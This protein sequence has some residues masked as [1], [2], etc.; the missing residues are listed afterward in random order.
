MRFAGKPVFEISRLGFKDKKLWF[1]QMLLRI[2]PPRGGA[3]EIHLRRSELTH[4]SWNSVSA[5]TV[6][7]MRSDWTFQFAGETTTGDDA[8]GITRE[9]FEIMTKEVF[10]EGIGLFKFTEAHNLAYQLSLIHI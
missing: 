5:L 2:R 6:E 1:N 10:N 8:G 4:D 9:W 3:T 7:Q